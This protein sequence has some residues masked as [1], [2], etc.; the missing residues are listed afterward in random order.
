MARTTG[1]MTKAWGRL[2]VTN[3][4]TANDTVIVNG[5]IYKFVATPSAAGDVDIGANAEASLANLALAINGTGTPGATTYYTGTVAMPSVIATSD[6]TTLTL[7]ARFAGTWGNDIHFAEG[8]DG[9]T[10][11]SIS[12]VMSGGAGAMHTF[13]TDLRD[14][15]QTNSELYADLDHAVNA[16][17]GA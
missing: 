12:R 15:E 13:L 5:E 17:S 3:Q 6:A 11:F 14:Y 2:T 4:F 10:T 8:T 9:G 7:T 16:A 1:T